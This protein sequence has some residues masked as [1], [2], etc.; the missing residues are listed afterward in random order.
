MSEMKKK[1]DG[2]NVPNGANK[3]KFTP[4]PW[5]ACEDGLIDKMV[6]GGDYDLIIDITHKNGKRN[7]AD[8]ALI[9]SAP[10]MYFALRDTVWAITD[11]LDA[12]TSGVEN[13][14]YLLAVLQDEIDYA[15]QVLK[16][17]RGEE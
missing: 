6:V 16:E 7:D 1:V 2:A 9:E 5:R 14:D 3:E 12:I 15:I 8:S 17:A 13:T 10:K 4:G 11:L